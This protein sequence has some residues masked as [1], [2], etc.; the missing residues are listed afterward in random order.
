MQA[1][2][3]G[4][5]QSAA[6]AWRASKNQLHGQAV[7]PVLATGKQFKAVV[8]DGEPFV[9][10][11]SI[12]R[13]NQE[14]TEVASDRFTYCK[15]EHGVVVFSPVVKG[16]LFLAVINQAKDDKVHMYLVN[17]TTGAFN[18]I[19]SYQTGLHPN[20][21]VFSAGKS[22]KL[23]LVVHN[24]SDDD[25]YVYTV[26][27]D[28]GALKVEGRLDVKKNVSLDQVLYNA[29]NTR[30]ELIEELFALVAK[31]KTKEVPDFLKKHNL[32]VD[33]DNFAGVTA[34]N[35][36][37]QNNQLEMA[38]TLLGLGADPKLG[39]IIIDFT[40][41]KWAEFKG[42]KEMQALLKEHGA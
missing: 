4:E 39:D 30:P 18:S 7:S 10:I 11:Y 13:A 12:N 36:A 24:K 34:L 19:G 31:G 17:Q 41:L 6:R 16:N 1:M 2:C 26:D 38:K 9:R 3:N 37:V 21:I 28:T 32:H 23:F 42:N 22:D 5:L 27:R 15:L 29:C 25:L 8:N 20:D 33:I 14:L 35:V 40:P